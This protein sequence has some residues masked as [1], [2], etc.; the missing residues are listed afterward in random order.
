MPIDPNTWQ[1]LLHTVFEMNA[2]GCRTAFSETVVTGLS[3]MIAAD[4][5]V[6]HVLDTKSQR[7][8]THMR[9]PSPYTDEEIAYYAAHSGEHPIGAHYLRHPEAGALRVS[10]V[11]GEEEWLASEYYRTCLQRLGLVHSLVLPVKIDRSVVVAL[12]FS[13]RAPDFTKEDCV[14]LDA[15]GPHLRLAWRQHENPWADRRELKCRRRL[16]DLGL[17]PRESEVLFWMTEGK[18]NREIA[19]LLGLSLGTVQ[20][21]VSYILAKLQLENR[22]AATVFAINRLRPQ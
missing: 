7:I 20:D 16:Q 17:S 6:F 14:L 1:Q 10:D 19:T 15:F 11:I 13:R 8:L 5:I 21:Y 4:V 12:S 9:P 3:E 18:V 22:H 2:S